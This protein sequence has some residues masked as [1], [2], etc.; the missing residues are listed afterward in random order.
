METDTVVVAKSE[1]QP[2]TGPTRARLFV[3]LLCVGLSAAA[4]VPF[5]FMGRTSNQSSRT[6][7]RMPV[8]H[9][10]HLHFEQMKSFY[11]NLSS[12]TI[13]P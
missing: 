9:D 2:A 11:N 3:L 12:G 5:F 13:Y 4:A 7:L 8:T 1:T 6:Q 10:M